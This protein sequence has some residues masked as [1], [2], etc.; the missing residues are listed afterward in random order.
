MRFLIRVFLVGVTVLAGSAL[1]P[2]AVASA[3][4]STISYVTY[5]ADDNPYSSLKN[6]AYQLWA[7][8]DQITMSHGDYNSTPNELVYVSAYRSGGADLQFTFAAPSGQSM[9]VGHYL[10]HE[11]Q[12]SSW[13][14]GE[15]G[16]TFPCSGVTGGTFDVRDIDLTAGAERVD[17]VYNVMCGDQGYQGELVV[18]EP[19]AVSDVLPM[20]QSMG[21][22]PTYPT[23]V[24]QARPLTY[25]NSGT[26]TL[27]PT[28]VQIS[29]DNANRFAVSSDTCT[30]SAV[31]PGAT[32]TVGVT[33]APTTSDPATDN[34]TLTITDDSA[35][36][37]HAIPLTGA[38]IPG[39]TNAYLVGE[40]G[41][42][43]IGPYRYLLAAPANVIDVAG[44]ADGVS[45]NGTVPGN[46]IGWT[47]TLHPPSG[48]SLAVGTYSGAVLD[49]SRGTAAGLTITGPAGHC[50]NTGA[51]S[52]TITQFD[53]GPTGR[54]VALAMTWEDHCDGTAVG[55]YGSIAWR[56]NSAAVAPPTGP[57][58][59]SDTN[60]PGTPY[61]VTAHGAYGGATIV[62]KNP[63]D[64]D[65][66]HVIVRMAPGRTPPAT[67]TSGIGVY[68][69]T[70]TAVKVARLTPGASYSFSVWAEDSRGNF[71]GY[72]HDTLH[73]T[74]ALFTTPKLVPVNVYTQVTGRVVNAETGTGYQGAVLDFYARQPSSTVWS[75]LG[76]A[77]TDSRGIAYLAIRVSG[78][79]YL[80]MRYA[81]GPH[82]GGSVSAA[83][84]P[85]MAIGLSAFYTGNIT[86]T[87]TEKVW[88][89]VYPNLA[90]HRI[91]LERQS[92]RTWVAFKSALVT[93]SSTFSFGFRLAKGTY[94]YRL[95]MPATSGYAA[96]VTAPFGVL[97][98]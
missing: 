66:A 22:T 53:V 14:P 34:A 33:F 67:P 63:H 41:D 15:G 83:Q 74:R 43:V 50:W 12:N 47:L 24:S 30:G 96:V 72:G 8:R 39:H 5:A 82:Y 36:G 1:S 98:S 75:K 46:R 69:G 32:C 61:S 91:Y 10:A 13:L 59:P 90:G 44:T 78:H 29:G 51:G 73:G 3:S 6:V 86:P 92:G 55:N 68:D 17:I 57:G 77:S 88:G 25:L 26:T 7:P 49:S 48:Q 79:P 60:P 95:V 58:S 76:S 28:G 21:F 71:S 37:S 20:P 9:A 45:A 64:V 35:E 81:G 11:W 97:V 4:A 2:I 27:H 89:T 16:V 84:H 93:R 62:W 40:T 19:S 94:T 56:A 85:A 70:S 65:L 23:A 80:A 38:P 87:G 31:A 52:Y 54:L 18:N 42:P